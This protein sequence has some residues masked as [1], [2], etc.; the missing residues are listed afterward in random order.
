METNALFLQLLRVALTGGGKLSRTPSS[1]EWEEILNA[2]VKQSVVGV[3]FCGVEMLPKEQMPPLDM[4]MD[5]SA[6]VSHIEEENRK[7][8]ALCVKVSEIFQ[9]EKIRACIL[10]GQGMGTLYDSPLRRMSGDIDVWMEGGKEHIVDYFTRN[11]KEVKGEDGDHH[12]SVTLKGGVP[13]EVH[14]VPVAM[15]SPKNNKVFGEWMKTVE[16]AQWGNKVALPE[17]AGCVYMPNFEFNSVFILLHLFHHWAFEG[18]GMKQM[19]D[20]FFLLKTNAASGKWQGASVIH[21]LGMDGFLSAMM[22][23]MKE[24]GL[25]DAYLLC[26]PNEKLGR[27]LLEDIL[28]VG[29]VSADELAY[30]KY[31]K[32]SKI[33]KG[34][35][36]FMRSMR[37][38]PYA[39]GEMCW[40]FI[41][42]VGS[43][44]TGKTKEVNS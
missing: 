16:A 40:A 24:L 15:Y 21:D 2:C 36:R 1:E 37:M 7:L 35:R 38:L 39:P 41:N 32:E 23:V 18:C 17:G 12:V 43:W 10:K 20:F 5:W 9:Q 13:M 6:V 27:R 31:S 19:L 11:F 26:A 4:I 14:W 30:G 34:C 29:T 22:W 44:A 8:N 3:G 33:H 28:T 42:N 25:D